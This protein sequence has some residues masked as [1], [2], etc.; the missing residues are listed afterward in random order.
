MLN[1]WPTVVRDLK[2][3]VDRQEPRGT[4]GSDFELKREVAELFEYTRDVED[5]EIRVLV[6]RH[7]LPFTM[8]IELPG[9]LRARW[10]A[11]MHNLAF[12]EAFP[13]VRDVA[14][15]KALGAVGRCGLT[16]DD[17]DDVAGQLLVTFYT[18]FDRFDV[19]RASV[20][21][22]ASRVMDKELNSI[23]RYRLAGRRRHLGDGS[24]SGDVT[25]IDTEC[26]SPVGA[27][28]LRTPALLAGLRAGTGPASRSTARDGAGAVL[29]H[30]QRTEPLAW[31]GANG[32]LSPDPA[33]PRALLAAGVG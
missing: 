30:A 23:L 9:G 25:E 28:L 26:L 20:R 7:G 1:P 18:R 8:E 10:E 19:D 4:S 13:T 27:T 5:G 33:A 16:H 24:L 15:Q 12:E 6:V 21:T 22:F 32:S 29:A 31:A 17:C 3:G 14:R 11:N 2:F